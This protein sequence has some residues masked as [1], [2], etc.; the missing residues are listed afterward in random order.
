M[1]L[2][3]YLITSSTFARHM[4]VL[5]NSLGLREL[6]PDFDR[7]EEYKMFGQHMK[8]WDH[9]VALGTRESSTK[10]DGGIMP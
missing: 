6:V 2:I 8:I 10:V 5:H 1:T 3:L 4:E 7:R 9:D